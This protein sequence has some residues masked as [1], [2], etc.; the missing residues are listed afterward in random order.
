MIPGESRMIPGESR[1][2]PGESRMFPGESRVFP[3]E[4]RLFPG[5]SHMIPGKWRVSGGKSPIR[6]AAGG[7]GSGRVHR[8]RTLKHNT[9]GWLPFVPLRHFVVRRF[10]GGRR[11]IPQ[12]TAFG[13]AAKSPGE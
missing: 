13:T 6:A 1:M 3:G 4:S 9:I 2:F 5:E 7:V 10:F 11:G 8:D 12:W